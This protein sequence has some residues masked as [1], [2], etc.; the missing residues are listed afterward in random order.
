MSYSVYVRRAA[1]RDVAQ[2]QKW[3][4]EQQRG[5]AAEFHVEFSATLGR[6][7]ET[8]LIYPALYRNVRRAVSHRFPYLVWYRVQ[9][10]R[11]TVL[12]CTHGKADPGKVLARL[13]KI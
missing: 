3:Y 10:S 11:V 4:E 8:P 2:A 6:L 12:A 5:L 7:T 13:R 1:E 9:N